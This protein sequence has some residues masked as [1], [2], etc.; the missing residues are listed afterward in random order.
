ME[1][2]LVP[3]L[4]ARL[5]RDGG[6]LVFGATEA[7]ARHRLEYLGQPLTSFGSGSAWS[8][9]VRVGDRWVEASAGADGLLG[10]IRITRSIEHD[11]DGASGIP[12]VYR[13]IDVFEHTMAEVGFLL[14]ASPDGH[15]GLRL[16]GMPGAGR[17]E[18]ATLTAW[19]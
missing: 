16:T 11:A 1:I 14:G 8:W 5:P 3:K 10:Q 4:G 7:D 9:R 18:C 19:T 17:A 15:P 12:V 13:G 2:E 6:L